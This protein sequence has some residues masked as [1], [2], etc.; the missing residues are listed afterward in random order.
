MLEYFL[1]MIV[2]PLGRAS[3]FLLFHQKGI[4]AKLTCPDPEFKIYILI[5]MKLITVNVTI[6]Q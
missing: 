6:S 1:D 5:I 3:L 2:L 4:L